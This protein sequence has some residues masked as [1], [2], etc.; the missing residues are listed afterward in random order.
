MNRSK[1]A[2]YQ[3]IILAGIIVLLIITQLV[4]KTT[5]GDQTANVDSE[6]YP[7]TDKTFDDFNVPGTR[8][9]VLTGTEYE[10]TVDKPDKYE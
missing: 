2:K 5:I 9:A 4:G 1:D 10:K 3:W 6:G 8:F 7:L